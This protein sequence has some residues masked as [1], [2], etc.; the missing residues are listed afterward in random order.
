MLNLILKHI[1]RLLKDENEHML[2]IIL[3]EIDSSYARLYSEI[4]RLR[5]EIKKD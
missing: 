3:H 5:S 2:K 1:Q 4:L